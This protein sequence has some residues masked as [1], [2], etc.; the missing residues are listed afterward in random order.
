MSMMMGR[1]SLHALVLPCSPLFFFFSLALAHGKCHVWC[2]TSDFPFWAHAIP[3]CNFSLAWLSSTSLSLPSS[4]LP[5]LLW[6][7]LPFCLPTSRTARMEVKHTQK[8]LF[9]VCLALDLTQIRPCLGNLSPYFCRFVCFFFCLFVWLVCPL[10]FFSLSLSRSLFL[11]VVAS[12][13]S[14][15]SFS[16]KLGNHDHACLFALH[17]HVRCIH[18]VS[19]VCV[20][21]LLRVC[22]M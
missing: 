11:V 6:F 7:L 4:S 18:A 10:I 19:G 16:L 17:F 14:A 20:N 8:F 3:R 13:C 12:T 9:W 22:A 1:W 15:A 5:F 21:K 2:A